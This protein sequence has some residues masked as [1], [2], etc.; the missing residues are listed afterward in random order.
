MG[1]PRTWTTKDGRIRYQAFYRNAK[2]HE[3]PAG[4][5]DSDVLND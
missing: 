2:G 5:F 4:V 3:Q 1:W